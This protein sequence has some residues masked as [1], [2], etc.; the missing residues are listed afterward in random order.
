[1]E[2]IARPAWRG[3]DDTLFYWH[4]SVPEPAS[5]EVDEH[6]RLG[7]HAALD[8][9]HAVRAAGGLGKWTRARRQDE[10][11]ADAVKRTSRSWRAWDA[12]QQADQAELD[13]TLEAQEAAADAE[14]KA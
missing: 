1:M 7:W 11:V 6:W 4:E 8:F 5:A 2:T 3:P 9:A 12:E 10:A 14:V 13:R